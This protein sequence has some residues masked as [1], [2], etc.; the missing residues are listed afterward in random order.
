MCTVYDFF[1]FLAAGFVVIVATDYAFE[2]HW[3]LQKDPTIVVG[4]FWIVAAY[5]VGHIIGNLSGH[6]L[7]RWIVRKRLGA[8]EET[9]FRDRG[10]QGVRKLFPGYH[11]R[12][13]E[14][15]QAR[16]LAK[17]EQL[18][19]IKKPGR[20]LFFHSFERIKHDEATRSRLNNFL[21]QYGFCR[22]MS[23]ALLLSALI[24][25]VGLATAD[26]RNEGTGEYAGLASIAAAVTGIG[27]FYRYLKYFREYTLEVF[28]SYAEKDEKG[29][30]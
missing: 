22:N 24:L 17:A 27:M 12:L 28:R 13:P 18:A 15:T 4:V 29:G 26:M 19:E 30:K 11:D 10:P 21:N 25:L 3:L 20:D 9:L 16:I 2:R 23:L 8:P 14:R 6:I 7:D 1:A 5:I